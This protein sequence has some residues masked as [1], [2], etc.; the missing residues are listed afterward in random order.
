MRDG[1]MDNSNIG[2]LK[3]ENKENLRC[4]IDG[5]VKFVLLGKVEAEALLE[6]MFLQNVE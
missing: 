5:K 3:D 4:R 2:N 1:K 6:K